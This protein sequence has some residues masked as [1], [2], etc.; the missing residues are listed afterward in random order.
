MARNE[1][2]AGTLFS[3]WSSF[4]SQYHKNAKNVHPLMASDSYNDIDSIHKYRKELI[5][6]ITKKLSLIQNG[7]Y[8]RYT[9]IH[10]HIC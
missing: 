10:I 8:H 6:N 5:Q 4:R 3:K 2:K 7:T 9:H 1:E